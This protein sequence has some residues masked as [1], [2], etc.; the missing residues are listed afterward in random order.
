M[1]SPSNSAFSAE[2]ESRENVD[3]MNVFSLR[4]WMHANSDVRTRLG[5]GVGQNSWITHQFSACPKAQ[6]DSLQ[7]E[8]L[9][10][11]AGGSHGRIPGT[12]QQLP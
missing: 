11:N 7:E 3:A 2:E 12:S 6:E 8:S 10:P 4:Q 5:S 9:G 1:I